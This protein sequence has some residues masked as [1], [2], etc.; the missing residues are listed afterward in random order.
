MTIHLAEVA[1][2]ERSFGSIAYFRCFWKKVGCQRGGAEI[3]SSIGERVLVCHPVVNLDV[4]GNS[5]DSVH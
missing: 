4:V 1:I 3:S 2:N 5:Y